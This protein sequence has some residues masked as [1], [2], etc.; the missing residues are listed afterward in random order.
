M[1]D[2]E[3]FALGTMTNSS[4]A[5]FDRR[6]RILSE[7]RHMIEEGG[8][9]GFSIRDL[10]RR[11]DVS[12]RT[13]Y[14]AF[15]S[16]EA[17]VA[18]AIKAYF[19]AFYRRMGFDLD[20]VTFEGA[21]QRQL[22]TTLRNLELPNYLHAV[23][24]LYFSPTLDAG[25]RTVLLDMGTRSWLPWLA[26]I[27]FARQV[28]RWVEI[29]RL[30]ADLSDIQFAK[31]HQWGLGALSDDAF[32]EETVRSVLSHLAGSLR[33]EA[34]ASVRNTLIDLGQR[35]GSWT[36]TRNYAVTQLTKCL[37]SDCDGKV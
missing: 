28:E 15:G 10:C 30:A 36:A 1:D 21:L 19:D 24:A 18:L 16:K 37:V 27:R 3:L 7:T 32:V 5:M 8:L 26:N 9:E 31:V 2:S 34:R 23:A 17:V 4:P 35:N 20:S 25:I 22:T 13:I 11:A 14:N 33:G 29:E 6:R 12:S